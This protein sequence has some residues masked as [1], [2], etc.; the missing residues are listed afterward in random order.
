MEIPDLN[1][2]VD[3]FTATAADKVVFLAIALDDK[4]SLEQF[5]KRVP[6]RY[7]IIDNGKFIA[8]QY[9]IQGFPTHVVVDASGKVYF[10]TVGLAPNTVYWLK[11]SVK[12]LLQ[13]QEN[14]TALKH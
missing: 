4:A 6:F 5:L 14:K 11:R 3:S 8:Q 7:N 13:K 9:G 10:H 1:Q 2:L 12:E